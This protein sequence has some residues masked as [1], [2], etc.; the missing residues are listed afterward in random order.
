MNAKDEPNEMEIRTH[1]SRMDHGGCGLIVK[2]RDGEIVS[3]KGDPDSPRSRGYLCPK[4][5]A[6]LEKLRHPKRLRFPMKRA[7]ERGSNQW[8]RISWEE[9]LEI[10]SEKFLEIKERYGA[11]A[12]CFC[13]GMPKG[14]EHFVLIRLANL[15]GSPNVVSVQDVC[16]APREVT[17]LHVCGFYPVADFRHK[18]SL[19]ILWGSNTTATNEEGVF[20]KLLLDQLRE[21]TALIIVDPRKTD[22]TDRAALHLQ[23]RPGSD[24]A[25]ALGMIKVIIEE[26]LYD[27]DFVANWTNGFGELAD[28][29]K[30]YSLEEIAQITWVPEKKIIEAARLY[31]AS[32]PAAIHWGNAIEQTRNNFDAARSLIAL[33]AICGNLDSPGGNIQPLD[34]P[35]APLGKF[36]RASKVPEKPKQMIHAHFG[37]IPKLMTVP[38]AYFRKAVLEGIPYQ[39]RAAYMQC[40]NPIMTWADSELTERALKSLEF[41]VVSDVF[42]T[43]TALYADI[44]LP[45]ATQFEFND[46]GHYGLGHGFIVAR[47]KIVD[48]PPECLPD[49]KILNELGKRITDPSEWYE[50]YEDLLNEVLAPSGLTYQQFIERG[51]L[52]GEERFF[53]YRVEGFKT[54]SGKVE[55]VLSQAVK[56]GANPLPDGRT[57][58]DTTDND[59]PLILTST[60]DR[61]YLHSSY[62]WIEGLRKLSDRPYARIHP[63]TAKRYGI[64]DGA[65][66][67]IETRHG[68]IVQ[69]AKITESV[70]PDVVVAAYGWWFPEMEPE[71]RYEWKRSNFNMLTSASEPGKAFGTCNMKGISCRIYPV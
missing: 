15:F 71:Q 65:D 31:A 14:L 51:Y 32:R 63:E 34:P 67:V 53:K 42:L 36:V 13:Q 62:R 1:C 55:L 57:L 44:V 19:V 8:K 12:V 24:T 30:S 48:P 6:S 9:A 38:P 29:V 3:I 52:A 46:I 22:L 28:Y 18:S 26:D 20:A 54:P 16:H 7:G 43:P 47:P 21:G 58:P 69:T 39:V 66:V 70:H 25:L 64:K 41:L 33:M 11:R 27:K 61:F 60:K 5:L 37:T 40:T 35:I 59:F 17:G 2:V 10:I 56:W 45:A 49:M 50:D 23:L 4:G 68:R